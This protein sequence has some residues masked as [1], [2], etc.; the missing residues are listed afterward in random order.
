MMRTLNA[1][2]IPRG[3]TE[4]PPANRQ[5]APP[6]LAVGSG[7]TS[8]PNHR[9]DQ[10]CL[11]DQ[12]LTSLEISPKGVIVFD[13]FQDGV[14]DDQ[15]LETSEHIHKAFSGNG[16][17]NDDGRV[18]WGEHL[19]ANSFRH[20]MVAWDTNQNGRLDSDE[21][22]AVGTRVW[23]DNG[24]GHVSDDELALVGPTVSITATGGRIEPDP[25]DR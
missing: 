21:L 7:V 18:D 12:A 23:T 15:D 16:D 25:E 14:I 2:T 20:R 3:T 11:T 8:A 24:D 6:K 4:S 5:W 22:N 13:N 1:L 9:D 19:R 17:L 10:V